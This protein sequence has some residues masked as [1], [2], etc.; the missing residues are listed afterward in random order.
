MDILPLK[1][2]ELGPERKNIDFDQ[3]FEP[4]GID[5]KTAIGRLVDMQKWTGS[6]IKCDRS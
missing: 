1:P 4:V 6:V 5:L 2:I 3:I